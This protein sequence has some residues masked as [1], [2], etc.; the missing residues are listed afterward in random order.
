MNWGA[1]SAVGCPCRSPRGKVEGAEAVLLDMGTAM[2]SRSTGLGCS[3]LQVEASTEQVSLPRD[4][5]TC[6]E[7][8]SCNQE[9]KDLGIMVTGAS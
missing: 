8:K 4:V 6:L 5:Y 9:V 1:V 7:I 3:Q 2:G